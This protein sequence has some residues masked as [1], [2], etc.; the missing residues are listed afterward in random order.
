MSTR[1]DERKVGSIPAP[2]KK[3]SE[4]NYDEWEKAII[5]LLD[6][7]KLKDNVDW[8]TS[9]IPT[10]KYNEDGSLSEQ[11]RVLTRPTFI[12]PKITAYTETEYGSVQA[13]AAAWASDKEA[14]RK[15]RDKFV[16][17]CDQV[18]GFLLSD[19]VCEPAILRKI[20]NNGPEYM[21]AESERDLP[22]L[23]QALSKASSGTA[24]QAV[25]KSVI[26]LINIKLE[27]EGFDTYF[28]DFLETYRKLTENTSAQKV[29]YEEIVKMFASAL[30]IM[31]LMKG[32]YH[33]LSTE[34]N[35]TLALEAWPTPEMLVAKWSRMLDASTRMKDLM[36]GEGKV[37]ANKAA[38][39]NKRN[40]TRVCFRCGEAGHPTWKCSKTAVCGLNG[41]KGNH[42]R[43]Y[44]EKAI[45]SDAAYEARKKGNKKG[46]QEATAMLTVAAPTTQ[47][48]AV[49]AEDPEDKN[50]AS[51]SSFMCTASG[52]EDEDD[53]FTFGDHVPLTLRSFLCMEKADNSGQGDDPRKPSKVQGDLYMGYD[54]DSDTGS[55]ESARSRRRRKRRNKR[56]AEKR[57]ELRRLGLPEPGRF[58][59]N[60]LAPDPNA[61]NPNSAA[62]Q[63]LRALNGRQI[64]SNEDIAMEFERLNLPLPEVYL[65]PNQSSIMDLPTANRYAV[66]DDEATVN[67]EELPFLQRLQARVDEIG[68]A[69]KAA[70]EG[71][72]K[73][74]DDP[75]CKKCGKL[76]HFQWNCKDRDG[77]RLTGEQD[78]TVTKETRPAPKLQVPRGDAQS[79]L[80]HIATKF[81]PKPSTIH[82]STKRRY[83]KDMAAAKLDLQSQIKATLESAAD[84]RNDSPIATFDIRGAFLLAEIDT[85]E[86]LVQPT[87][88]PVNNDDPQSAS[89]VTIPDDLPPL[90][91][92]RS[93]TDTD[94][95][96]D[97]EE[98]PVA[99]MTTEELTPEFNAYMVDDG[100]QYQM[101]IMDT[102]SNGH[103][104]RSTSG[105][106]HVTVAQGRRVTGITG[107]SVNITHTGKH[108][109]LG[110]VF[111]VPDATADLV[112]VPRL[113]S[114]G[115]RMT[116]DA[117]TIIIVDTEG[118]TFMTGRRRHD[119]L[120]ETDLRQL[121]AY[122][123]MLDPIVTDND[124]CDRDPPTSLLGLELNQHQIARAHEARE[125]HCKN[126]HP[127]KEAERYMIDNGIFPDTKLTSR[128]FENS[129]ELLGPCTSCILGKMMA[130]TEP[131]RDDDDHDLQVGQRIYADLQQ[132]RG[133]GPSLGGNTQMLLLKDRRSSLVMSVPLK[134]K[135]KDHIYSACKQIVGFMHSH[136]HTVKEF[137]FDSEPTLLSVKHMLEKDGIR[138]TYTPAGLHNKVIER[139]TQ[140]VKRKMRCMEAD[141]PYQIP[142]LLYFELMDA[143]ITCLN[144]TPNDMTGPTRSPYEIVTGLRPYA[145]EF[146]FGQT[147][148]CHS[149]RKDSPDQRAEWCIFIDQVAETPGNLRLFIPH[150]GDIYSRRKF[151]PHNTYPEEWGYAKSIKMGRSTPVPST[152][153][154]D[155]DPTIAAAPTMTPNPIGHPDGKA[156]PMVPDTPTPEAH[157]GQSDP[158]SIIPDGEQIHQSEPPRPSLTEPIRPA[159]PVK[160]T[161]PTQP[162]QIPPP[163]PEPRRSS[164]LGA[165]TKPDRYAN[166]SIAEQYGDLYAEYGPDIY[167]LL[168]AGQDTGDKVEAPYTITS[169]RLSLKQALTTGPEE[170]QRMSKTAMEEEIR[171]LHNAKVFKWVHFDD[172]PENH[173][174]RTCPS[175]M[176]M[177]EKYNADGSYQKM[178]ARLVA[179]G[180]YVDTTL[181]GDTKAPTARSISVMIALNRA[182]ILSHEIN[183]GDISTAFLIPD[184]PQD[185]EVDVQYVYIPASVAAV[186]VRLYPEV[187][188][189]LDSKG[190]LLG[191]LQKWLYGLPQSAERFATHLTGTMSELGFTRFI[192][193]KCLFI[194]DKLMVV[195]HVDDL[196]FTGPKD[197]MKNFRYEIGHKYQINFQDGDRHSYL[198]LDIRR[199]PA[200]EGEQ[201]Y[202]IR[203]TQNGYRADVVS[204]FK[205]LC[206]EYIP[207]DRIPLTPTG[208]D[209]CDESKENTPSVSVN[210]YASLVMSMMY[211]ARFT[212]PDILFAC[213]VLSTWASKPDKTHMKKACRVLKYLA[214]S[215]NKGLTFR[216]APLKCTMGADAGHAIHSDGR[217][218]GGHTCSLGSAVI[219]VRSYKVKMI[220][221]SST[222]TEFC[223]LSDLSKIAI[224][225]NAMCDFI[226]I[227]VRPTEVLQDNT[228]AIWLSANEGSFTRTAHLLIRRNF[229]KEAIL[230]GEIKVMHL[231]TASMYPDLLT[232]PNHSEDEIRRHMLAMGMT[233]LKDDVNPNG[234]VARQAPS[235][236][237]P[238]AGAPTGARR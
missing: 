161:P 78:K 45:A 64:V 109:H 91:S 17:G 23:W 199:A 172:L 149:V 69:Q 5:S 169:Y 20:E 147:G 222:E 144:S 63:L 184:V 160:T 177:K 134:T 4:N 25:I 103:V 88:A 145:K 116:G 175:H 6:L 16:E 188:R 168:S 107:N 50:W 60:G 21:T 164:R 92:L 106:T 224:Y 159:T 27:G 80:D 137:V 77:T 108:P 230:E 121:K 204:R 65:I 29:S 31:N 55:D 112:S 221:L 209:F 183:T 130:P 74:P 94:S 120:Y 191:R 229:V 214:G 41:C 196:L 194:R 235:G 66:L 3:L 237:P 165:G 178:K 223:V 190:R 34:V 56:R 142:D 101:A 186:L 228:S 24:S 129:Y 40:D 233:T 15:R 211:L 9:R 84:P 217:G 44:H 72:P 13:G 202:A 19:D 170:R 105:L 162:T 46:K 215:G 113:L 192:G 110:H 140:D 67:I 100:D 38:V 68:K 123:S 219:W 131:T 234:G 79:R 212:R 8:M 206:D 187:K 85:Q 151:I 143:A 119:G 138:C 156:R 118:R 90:V 173:K 115:R 117:H 99:L 189:F 104:L 176:F 227:P 95:D 30:F 198:G 53:P 125:W 132:Q 127:G 52:T 47:P 81:N 37:Q 36:Q 236:L 238:G 163:A 111:I 200:K 124:D 89:P 62:Q 18:W 59:W 220:T 75:L 197:Q 48:A 86:P 28:H 179:G 10:K 226:G 70:T 76:G 42:L 96:S 122:A 150:R 210:K 87:D 58:Y 148:V 26:S 93:S 208:P 128:D 133:N 98:A 218:H 232:K 32:D 14:M 155:P 180:N 201:A 43:E 22:W 216:K 7:H 73:T 51:L 12:M 126:G 114:G 49:T 154:D 152:R 158:P 35:Q 231:P 135:G 139:A 182:V 195:A 157:E 171:S 71:A 207:A 82:D 181:I 141:L 213:T 102:G 153:R 185:R 39:D 166:M 1:E 167:A 174:N 225:V 57:E 54:P 11:T 193:D 146:K 33:K 136:R 61:P 205:E 83:A 203:V 2:K 97:D